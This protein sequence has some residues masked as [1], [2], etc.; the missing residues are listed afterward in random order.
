MRA[1][2]PDRVL[3]EKWDDPA[4]CI[5]GLFADEVQR[6]RSGVDEMLFDE[7][8][9]GDQHL[10]GFHIATPQHEDLARVGCAHTPERKRSEWVW[11]PSL[12]HEDVHRAAVRAGAWFPDALE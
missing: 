12:F 10:V 3:V 7:A 8:A 2:H 4:D 11:D 6:G 1:V 5:H 9:C